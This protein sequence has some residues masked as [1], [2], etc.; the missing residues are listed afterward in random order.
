VT[1]GRAARRIAEREDRLH[2]GAADAG[3]CL[4]VLDP[5]GARRHAV[6]PRGEHHVLRAAADVHAARRADDRDDELGAEHVRRR[7]HR[8]CELGL[9]RLDDDELAL[10]PVARAAGQPARVE[11]ARH[12]VLG[13]GPVGVLPYVALARYR[14]PGIHQ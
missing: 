6:V 7:V 12:H 5:V 11:D 4:G 1:A 2:L 14:E 3:G 9:L 10:L 13:H 8:V